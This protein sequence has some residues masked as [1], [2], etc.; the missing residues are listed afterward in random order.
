MSGIQDLGNGFGWIYLTKVDGTTIIGNQ[1]NTPAAVSQMRAAGNVVAPVSGSRSAW[2]KIT[3]TAINGSGSATSLSVNGIDQLGANVV[4]TGLTSD[5]AAALISAQLQLYMPTAGYNYTSSCVNN[6]IYLFGPPSAGSS[7]NG[8][9]P[10]L[11]ST[12]SPAI[13]YTATAFQNGASDNGIFDQSVGKRFFL[14]ADYGPSGIPN[15][16]P[17]SPTSLAGAIEISKFIISRGLQT[18]LFAIDAT[19]ANYKLP[20]IERVSA[21]TNI[22]VTPQS[23]NSGTLIYINPTDF[24]DG[25]IVFVRTAKS[26]SI[27]TNNFAITVES[28]DN[29]SVPGV[30]NIYLT[31]GIAYAANARKVIQLQYNNDTVLGPSFT[32]V[33]RSEITQLT[34]TVVGNSF[35]MAEL[36]SDGHT[37]G[38]GTIRMLSTLTNPTTGVAY[39]NLS[40]GSKWPRVNSN[41][42]MDV[43]TMDIDWICHQEAMLTMWLQGY[44]TLWSPGGR[45]YCPSRTL[46]LPLDQIANL[47]RA[48]L[49]FSFKNN[50]SR[51][52]NFTGNDL[53][54]FKRYFTN[55]TQ[56]DGANSYLQ[57][58]AYHFHDYFLQGNGGNSFN[59]IAFQLGAT[60]H[61]T[62]NNIETNDFGVPI[63]LEFC[64]EALL[65]NIK[66]VSY[67]LYG[68]YIASGRWTGASSAVA[69][70]NVLNIRGHR[71]VCVA[72]GKTPTAGIFTGGNGSIELDTLTFEGNSGSIHHYLHE[73]PGAFGQES[74]VRLRN[75]YFE[76]AGASRAAIKFKA[77]KGDFFVDKWNNTVPYADMPVFIEV[78]HVSPPPS[79]VRQLYIQAINAVTQQGNGGL[80]KFR[81]VTQQPIGYGHFFDVRDVNM[82]NNVT[83]NTAAN[84]DTSVANSYIP[85]NNQVNFVPAPI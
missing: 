57:S 42:T 83:L 10:I 31:D 15:T 29:L 6:I 63:D 34:T 56:C 70:S 17:A 12:G 80:P 82:P 21:I 22:Y 13:V 18:A 32:E 84:F 35:F 41:Y 33:S 8:L 26:T 71:N 39:T 81:A 78:E 9:L 38:M 77:D 69:G 37:L 73:N 2:A 68:S 24:V 27:G 20:T 19:L 60:N 40:A 66:H 5:Q 53:I 48:S 45:G 23:G 7:I 75:L 51:W 47:T 16:L 72:G 46:S 79:G 58:Y 67:G 49:S 36:F 3:I 62:F 4:V 14:N 11:S 28:A 50:G 65:T 64:L 25:D 30:G 1:P 44:T 43:T 52:A 59:D 85:L 61:S 55:Q 54:L 74:V 76:A